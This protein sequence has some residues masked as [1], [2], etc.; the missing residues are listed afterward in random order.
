MTQTSSFFA[1][2]KP[3][4]EKLKPSRNQILFYLAVGENPKGFDKNIKEINSINKNYFQLRNHG[5]SI[6]IRSLDRIWTKT[7]DFRIQ[8]LPKCHQN[9]QTEMYFSPRVFGVK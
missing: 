1:K 9:L 5:I 7:I 8:I 2:K 4:I 3:K 6:G